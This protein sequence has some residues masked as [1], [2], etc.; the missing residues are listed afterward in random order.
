MRSGGGQSAK[1][2]TRS[3]ITNLFMPVG[4]KLLEFFSDAPFMNEGRFYCF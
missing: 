3:A 2:S 1:R 4:A